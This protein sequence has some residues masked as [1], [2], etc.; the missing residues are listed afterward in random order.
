MRI[1]VTLILLIAVAAVPFCKKAAAPDAPA[2]RVSFTQ[3]TDGATVVSPVKVGMSVEGMSVRPA[4]EIVPGT[5]HFHILIDVDTPEEG[6]VVPAD[7]KHKHYGKGQTE[8]E[9]ELKP[10]QHKLTLLF[11]D[12][13]HQSY[14]PKMAQTIQVTVK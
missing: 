7:D 12:G 10:G 3:P 4:G 1:L 9:L 13:M 8:T 5:G 6:K 14:G 11:A 2:A